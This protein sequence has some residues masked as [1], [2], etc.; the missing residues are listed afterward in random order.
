MRTRL[1]TSIVLIVVLL[2]LL[3]V[4]SAVFFAAV[5]ALSLIASYEFYRMVRK[6]DTKPLPASLFALVVLAVYSLSALI[7]LGTLSEALFF[8][9]VLLLLIVFLA[10]RVFT[11]DVNSATLFQ[12]ALYI[13]LPFASLTYV[14]AQGIMALLYLLMLA[15]LTDVFAYF[16]GIRFGKH[17]LA[18]RISPKKTVEGAIGG[19]LIAVG[20]ATPFALYFDLFGIGDS[21]SSIALVVLFSV[22]VSLIAQLGDLIASAFKRRYDIKDFSNLM[23]GHG[24][25]LDRFDSTMFAATVLTLFLLLAEAI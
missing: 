3:F 12:G 6:Q 11:H 24:G 2:P 4:P 5:A 15:M 10:K 25:I 17:K 23:P 21:F 7:L 1:I 22:M 20:I 14:H 8:P 9:L 16:T 19:T 18:P 13:G